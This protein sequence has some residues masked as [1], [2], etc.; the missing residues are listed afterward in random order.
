MELPTFVESGQAALDLNPDYLSQL[1]KAKQEDVRV[2][3]ARNQHLPE[4]DLKASYGLN[5]L[6]TDPGSSWEDIEQRAFPSFSA[7]IELRVPFTGGIKGRRELEAARLRKQQALVTLKETET[8]VL[9]ALENALHKV[10]S[11]ARS[12]RNYDNVVTFSES[13]LATEKARLEA[14]KVSSRRV[15]E[16]DASLF[17]A[18]NS[19][20]EA[21]VQYERARLELELVQGSLL[22]SRNLDLPQKELQR[23]TAELLRGAG[24]TGGH[25]DNFSREL[26]MTYQPR[27]PYGAL[28]RTPG[29]AGAPATAS[30]AEIQ[31]GVQRLRDSLSD[32]LRDPLRDAPA[33]T[34]PAPAQPTP[35]STK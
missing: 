35:S 29:R 19:V 6:G 9:N 18:R 4:L 27:L 12:A 34:P 28:P 5:G 17:E 21:N 10:E 31:H 16:V 23:R 7:G 15:L 14:G 30:P 2:A 32:P 3:Y 8:Q 1:K 25:L 13:L 11:A 22:R 33:T 24:I 26:G 20:V